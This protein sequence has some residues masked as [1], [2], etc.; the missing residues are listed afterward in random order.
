VLRKWAN[1]SPGMEFR[2]FIYNK[3]LVGISQRDWR[4]Y[5][6][7]IELEKDIFAFEIQEFVT[8]KILHYFPSQ[9][10]TY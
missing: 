2:C 1:L 10:C 6:D 3:R 9:N 8:E 7:F 5:Y 4:Q